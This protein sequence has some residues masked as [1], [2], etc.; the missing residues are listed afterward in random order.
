MC[1]TNY[2]TVYLVLCKLTVHVRI[3]VQCAALYVLVLVHVLYV[4]VLFSTVTVYAPCDIMCILS[5][6]SIHFR[7]QA[8]SLSDNKYLGFFNA[9]SRL[10]RTAFG[11]MPFICLNYTGGVPKVTGLIK[12]QS[13]EI[14][15]NYR[16]LHNITWH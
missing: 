16:L 5:Q 2:C 1:A 11:W 4:F 8:L 10:Q 3:L 7:R 6:S 14:L 12:M 13:N 15:C 9:Q